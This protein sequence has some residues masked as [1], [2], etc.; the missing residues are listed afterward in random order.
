MAARSNDEIGRHHECGHGHGQ[1]AP[2]SRRWL[3]SRS[4]KSSWRMKVLAAIAPT[5]ISPPVAGYVSSASPVAKQVQP[6]KWTWMC[7]LSVGLAP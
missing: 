1:C 6:A 4:E 5:K 7:A 3:V 2:V